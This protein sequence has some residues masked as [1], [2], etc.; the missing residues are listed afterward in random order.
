MTPCP[1]TARST[2]PRRLAGPPYG[3]RDGGV[4]EDLT[5]VQATGYGAD[6]LVAATVSG[7]GRIVAL[8]IDP[9]VIDPDDPETLADLIIV[10]VDSANQ[11]VQ[12][13]RAASL[14]VVTDS[15]LSGL[16]PMGPGHPGPRTPGGAAS[17]R[18]DPRTPRAPAVL[19]ERDL[20]VAVRGLVS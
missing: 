10:A 3:G 2:S 5:G 9:S 7:D 16:R 12:E 4:Q 14:A 13:Q 20:P 6:G 11:A 17:P 18:T 1:T 8:R 15:L 19:P